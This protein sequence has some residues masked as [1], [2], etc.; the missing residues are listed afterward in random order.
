MSK[1]PAL[2]VLIG[3]ARVSTVE[4]NLDL[5]I[6]A[7]R[8]MGC[9][10]IFTDKASGACGD[11][12]GLTAA[13][14]A[15]N[16]GDTLAVWKLD[17]L[18]R[19]ALHLYSLLDGLRKRGCHFKSATDGIDTATATGSLIFGILS[20][21]AQFERDLIRE[22]TKAGLQA[23]K[24]RGTHLGRPKA[25]NTAQLQ[26]LPR[27]LCENLPRREIAA[28]LNCSERTLYRAI[29]ELSQDHIGG[30]PLAYWLDMESDSGD[31]ASRLA[32]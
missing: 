8:A 6:T 2:T 15:L 30:L 20:A 12:D 4:Q 5:Q 26:Q 16:H 3:Y 14:A 22:R 23:A 11:R 21:I 28:I 19:S 31:S 1:A 32:P 10:Q 9:E 24:D 17:R 7:L 25:L 29:S 18:G 13:L 27:L